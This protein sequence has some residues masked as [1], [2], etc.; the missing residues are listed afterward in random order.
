MLLATHRRSF[1]FHQFDGL[2]SDVFGADFEFLDQFPG[3]A[4]IAESVLYPDRASNDRNI[5]KQRRFRDYSADA[6][7]QRADLVFFRVGWLF[8]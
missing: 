6:P 3:S 4:G 1:N 5:V 2:L 8:T 7:C